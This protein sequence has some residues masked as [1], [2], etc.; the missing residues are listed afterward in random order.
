MTNS[1]PGAPFVGIGWYVRSWARTQPNAPALMTPSGAVR[2]YAELNSRSTRLGHALLGLGCERGDR[3]AIWLGNC[4]EYLDVYLACA[5]AG[6]VVVPV[7]T[8]FTATEADYV[9]GDSDARVLV[10]GPEMAERAELLHQNQ[11]R[12]RL[13][14]LEAMAVAASDSPLPDPDASELFLI[15]Y[16]S[17]TT[18]APKGAEL[19][20]GSVERLALTNALSCR[21]RMGSVHVFGMSL[22]F[23]ATVPAHVLP[24]L[25][26]GGTTVLH[27]SWDTEALLDSMERHRG[28]F[29][30]VPSPVLTEVADAVR[31]RPQ[32]AA[33]L[34]GALHSASKAPAEHLADLVDALGDRV[35]EGWGMTENSGGL[36]TASYPG[37]LTSG[38]PRLLAGAGRPVPGTEVEVRS[39]D[40]EGVGQLWVRSPAL[41]RGYRN[42]PSA[43]ASVLVDGWFATGDLGTVRDGL[44]TIVDRRADLINSGGMN[45]Y[46]SEVEDVLL[47]SGFVS[48]CAVVGAPHPRWGQVPVAFVVSREREV[49]GKLNG[50]LTERLADYKRPRKILRLDQLPRNAA[51]KIERRRLIELASSLD[52][53]M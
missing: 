12:V 30:I 27:P 50:Y 29:L 25:V 23:T 20:H 35:I 33:T 2:S 53:D 40:P 32:A 41:F 48:E 49:A 45:V 38:D 14:G 8:R 31:A 19:T 4:L 21:Y 15:G 7:N 5:K 13:E 52:R 47:R 11:I 37:D 44:V 39:P 10:L 43:T 26:V 17:G 6:L 42:N 36:F 22:S 16:T 3:V 34:I 9:L 46:P 1:A 18:G 51:S 24:H 28:N